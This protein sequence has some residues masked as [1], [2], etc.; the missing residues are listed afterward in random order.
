M[1]KSPFLNSI[2]EFMLVRHYSL[3]TINQY[4]YLLD[5][6]ISYF[7][8]QTTSPQ[9]VQPGCRTVSDPLVC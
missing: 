4:L 1:A 5:S 9:V 6:P 2:R 7:S 8:S 3:R